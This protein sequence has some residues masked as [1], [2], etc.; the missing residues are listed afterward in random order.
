MKFILLNGPA[1]S[2]KDTI[3][4]ALCEALENSRHEKFAYPI[5]H[6]IAA[7]FRMTQEQY[8]HYFESQAKNAETEF[9]L[10]RTP[11]SV[12]IDFSEIFMKPR[13]GHKVFAELFCRRIEHAQSDTI[14]V[15]SDCGFSDECEELVRQFGERNVVVYR[16]QR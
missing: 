10:G 15:V 3:A 16:L 13:L 12:L 2:G 4:A 1:G 5:K 8:Q 11:R 7:A 9:F 14:F 6:G